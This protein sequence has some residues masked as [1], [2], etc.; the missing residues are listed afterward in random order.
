M[1][2]P[3]APRGSRSGLPPPPQQSGAFRAVACDAIWTAIKA[4]DRGYLTEG[5]CPLC[6]MAPDTIGHRTY[7]CIKTEDAVREAVPRWF[8]EEANRTAARGAF[9]TTAIIPHP[10]DV[11]PPPRED[12]TCLVEHHTLEGAAA[13]N[14][15]NRTHVHGGV[16]VDGSCFP[17]PLRGLARAARAIRMV[18]PLGRPV[19]TL[20]MAVPRHLPQT[21][22]VAENLATAVAYRSARG[23]ADIAGDCLNVVR[24]FAGPVARALRPSNKYARLVVSAYSNIEQW[25]SIGIRWVKAHRKATGREEQQE[26]IDIAANAAVDQAA[27]DAVAFHPPLGID[28]TAD[29]DYYVKRA[30][31]VVAAVAAAM[32]LFLPAPTD[33]PRAP[34][35]ATLEEAR[36][37]RKHLWRYAAGAWRCAACGDYAT[38]SI[39]PKYRI[40]QACT[41][42]DIADSAPTFADKGHALKTPICRSSCVP[43]AAPGGTA[44]HEG[45]GS[46]APPPRRRGGRPSRVF[47]ADGTLCSRKGAT[48]PTSLGNVSPSPPPTTALATRGAPSRTLPPPL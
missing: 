16:Y 42:R 4:R 46:G 26:A 36:R 34:R 28:I 32:R 13:A 20:K 27:K 3:S 39:L 6:K 17:S 1:I 5:D 15:D 12:V 9:W 19:K 37:D 45:W 43:S 29:V 40:H 18:C 21:A 47:S 30:P 31:H 11:A 25:R 48:A 2:S 10:V 7:G 33:L 38:A 41:G 24:A 23:A 14:D 35:P 22:Q 44:A 8:W